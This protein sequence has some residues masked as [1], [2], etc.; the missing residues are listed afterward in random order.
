MRP[1]TL[2]MDLEGTLISNAVSQIP[3]PG[4]YRFLEAIN[5]IFEFTVIYT[6]VPEPVFRNIAQ[7]LVREGSAPAWFASIPYIDWQGPTKDL[8][9]VCAISGAVLLLD[10]HEPYIHPG[11]EGWWIE[12][13]LFGFPY[14]EEDRGLEAVLGMIRTRLAEGS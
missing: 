12:A 6:T 1:I 8:R 4:L 3:R 2:A 14:A 11:Q 7:L 5:D 10:D 9:N 13:P